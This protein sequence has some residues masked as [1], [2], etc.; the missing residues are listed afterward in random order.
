MGRSIMDGTPAYEQIGFL[1]RKVAELEAAN[2]KLDGLNAALDLENKEQAT[3]IA[4]L[5]AELKDC[6]WMGKDVCK[7]REDYIREN[8]RLRDAASAFLR[9]LEE[10]T[11]HMEHHP[12][13][14]VRDFF[15]NGKCLPVG[16]GVLYNLRQAL[17][18][19]R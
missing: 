8:Q 16:D 9:D 19:D 7:D 4:E 1:E 3:R 6:K 15:D 10:R 2:D 11:S 18:K 17:E 5:E 14:A 13:E 12:D